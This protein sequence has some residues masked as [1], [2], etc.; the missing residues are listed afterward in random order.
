MRQTYGQVLLRYRAEGST[1]RNDLQLGP[2]ALADLEIRDAKA[3]VFLSQGILESAGHVHQAL[4]IEVG[5][6]VDH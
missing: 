3:V 1:T 5:R 6:A 2:V 4:G